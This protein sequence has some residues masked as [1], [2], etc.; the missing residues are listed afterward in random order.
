MAPTVRSEDLAAYGSFVQDHLGLRFTVDDQVAL[1]DGLQ[2][3]LQQLSLGSSREFA[4]RLRDPARLREEV[5]AAAQVLTIGE[6][7]FYRYP[8]QF[9]ALQEVALPACW[10]ERPLVQMLSAGCSTGEE[11]YTLALLALQHPM[12]QQGYRAQVTGVDVNPDVLARARLGRYNAWS[13]RQDARLTQSAHVQSDGKGYTVSAT[14][15]N[16]VRF[17]QHNLANPSDPLWDSPSFDIIFC[18]N[19][20]I[21]FDAEDMAG[22]LQRLRALLRPGGFL[23]LGHA[24]SMRGVS[25]EVTLLHT[26]EC[27]YYQ[28]LRANAVPPVAPPLQDWMDR[29]GASQQRLAT[30]KPA[31]QQHTV[32]SAPPVV[33]Q[34]AQASNTEEALA[35]AM[36]LF[37]LERF[38]DALKAV[39]SVPDSAASLQAWLLKAAILTNAGQFAEAVT[40]CQQI[41]KSDS[42]HAGAYC[43]LTL[44]REHTG[45]HG[46]AVEAARLAATLD[47]EFAMPRLHLGRLLQKAGQV[48]G[49]RDALRQAERL[50]PQ[51]DAARLAL[52]GGGFSRAALLDLCRREL[53]AVGGP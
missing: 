48:G 38:A 46:G 44:C 41:L 16:A 27:F 36:Q 49:A 32:L 9:H 19:V 45:D 22:V 6:T 35:R 47:T 30:L 50:L 3:R 4:D 7:Y 12:A 40:V 33:A 15:R 51:E 37:A 39:A 34:V 53:R 18:R 8:E 42:L 13:F 28:R 1:R 52:F 23:F 14:V 29:I 31:V 5:A 26:H 25:S 2:T 43:L 10:Q 20:L 24:E 17:A 21:Y 11:A